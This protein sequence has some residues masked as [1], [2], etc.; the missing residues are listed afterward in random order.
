MDLNDFRAVN[1]K[2]KYH[3]VPCFFFPFYFILFDFPH[4]IPAI[5]LAKPQ[6]SGELAN[7]WEEGSE[8]RS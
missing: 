2:R 4:F 5:F 1:Y 6:K 8:S 7:G 3:L